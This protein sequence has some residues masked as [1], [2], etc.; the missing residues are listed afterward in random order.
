MSAVVV[1]VF[2]FVVEGSGVQEE[3]GGGGGRDEAMAAWMRV[4]RESAGVPF[5]E[6]DV[7]IVEGDSFV[8]V[9]FSSLGC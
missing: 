2:V 7:G 3:E 5:W 8:G 9:L 1:V 6:G 4:K